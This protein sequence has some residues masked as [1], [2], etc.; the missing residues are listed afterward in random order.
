MGRLVL[1]G[2]GVGLPVATQIAG[3]PVPSAV[4]GMPTRRAGETP[5]TRGGAGLF[6]FAQS[7]P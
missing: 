3:K 7:P 1:G 6:D 4:E 5:A 2:A